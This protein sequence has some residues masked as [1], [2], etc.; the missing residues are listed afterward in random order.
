[1]RATS[2]PV[3]I[4]VGLAL[5][6]GVVEPYLELAWKCRHGFETSEA[7]VWG[8]SL[9]PLG[10]AAGLLI[11]APIAFVVLMLLRQVWLI[12]WPGMRPSV[13]WALSLRRCW[14]SWGR[15]RRGETL[16]R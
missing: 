6:V 13:Q 4:C 10:H 9:L 11:V 14:R 7:C 1:M 12:S 8:R 15:R 3:L 5:A 16:G 2:R